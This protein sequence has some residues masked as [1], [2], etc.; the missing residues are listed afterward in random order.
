MESQIL[1]H[2]IDYWFRDIENLL[3]DT[4]GIEHIENMIKEGYNQGEL[5]QYDNEQEFRGWWEIVK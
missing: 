4:C 5:C 3:I 1:L 2:N